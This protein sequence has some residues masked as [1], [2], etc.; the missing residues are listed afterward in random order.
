MSEPFDPL[1]AEL[2]SL[3]PA[4][5]SSTTRKRIAQEIAQAHALLPTRSRWVPRWTWSLMG[6]AAACLIAVSLLRQEPPAER[7]SSADASTLDQ[8]PAAAFDDALPSVWTYHQ[9]LLRSPSAAE[10]LLDRHAVS[11]GPPGPPPSHFFT[12]SPRELLLQGE[13]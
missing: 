3:R 1:E 4:N 8:P 2:H 9:A 10:A 6:L 12:H 13:L 5:L 7:L 11:I